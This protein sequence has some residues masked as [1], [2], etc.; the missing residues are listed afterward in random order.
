MIPK[1]LTEEEREKQRADRL[2]RLFAARTPGTALTKEEWEALG[3]GP[4]GEQTRPLTDDPMGYKPR[5]RP[6]SPTT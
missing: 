4:D 5:P 2:E 6:E 3:Y 1:P